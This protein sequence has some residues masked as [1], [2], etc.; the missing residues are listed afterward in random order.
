MDQTLPIA[1]IA[2]ALRLREKPASAFFAWQARI[3]AAVAA[4]PGFLSIELAPVAG[5]PHEWRM[6]V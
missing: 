2:V 1:A 5:G 4:H 6:V 3:A